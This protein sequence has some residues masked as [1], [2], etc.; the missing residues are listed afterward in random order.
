MAK[1]QKKIKLYSGHGDP[2]EF[3]ALVNRKGLKQR[4][5]DFF[6]FG[7]AL[8]FE[9]CYAVGFVIIQACYLAGLL[10]VLAFPGVRKTEAAK[11]KDRVKITRISLRNMAARLRLPYVRFGLVIFL[12]FLSGSVALFKSASFLAYGFEIK[13]KVLGVASEGVGHLTE[14]QKQL[15]AQD[16]NGAQDQLNQALHSFQQSQKDIQDTGLIFN[17]LLNVL[18][19]K[20]DA[21]KIL[22]GAQ[23]AS[24][25]ALSLTNFYA[26][27]G[28]LKFT[29]DGINAPSVSESFDK[30][31][32]FLETGRNKL[33]EASNLISQVDENNVP[34]KQRLSFVQ[35]K[36][37]L[38]NVSV[39]LNSFSSVFSV[40][41]N[42]VG[43]DKK[44]LVL[45]ENN[46]ELRPTGGFMGTFGSFN[47]SNGLIKS[48]KISS[49]YDLD[50]QLT[51]RIA[52]PFPLKQ[53]STVWHLRDSNWFS[54]FPESA[55]KI[56]QFYEKEGGETPDMTIVLT[57]NIVSDL[58]KITGPI[59][60][61]AY[62]AV[63]DS[64]NFV[65]STQVITSVNYDKNLNKPKQMLADFFP[66]LLQHLA[67]LKREQIVDVLTVF[68]KNLLS[69][70]VVLFSHDANLQSQLSSFNWTGELKNTD[71][72]FLQLTYA[73]LNGNK[74]DL[75][76]KTDVK[77]ET[78][79]AQDQINNTLTIRRTSTLPE[80][81]QFDSIGF[82]RI[83]VPEGSTLIST[84]GFATTP[85]AP[86]ED[87]TLKTDPDVL[88]WE[89]NSVK[90]LVSGTIIGKESGKTI[91][92]NWAQV[93][94]G[95]TQVITIKYKLPFTLK[96]IDHYSLLLQKQ[97]GSVNQTFEYSINFSGK[98]LEWKNF[99][100]DNLEANNL[101]G[102][103][104]LNRDYFLGMVFSQR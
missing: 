13:N 32:G 75:A 88:A 78:E 35:A 3:R 52:A 101:N 37:Q 71:R 30:M 59:K 1:L 94:G 89:S 28:Q 91:F 22:V 104:D 103:F 48:S 95:R 74:T 41:K 92:G 51:E 12:I 23:K 33:L 8:I 29:P 34:E 44:I 85:D 72:D 76:I 45:F 67:T 57:P 7:P 38:Q 54:N 53:V 93:W 99:S 20:R 68:Q 87:A 31:S 83:Y 84:S 39:A 96:N 60:M 2:L 56:T 55:K 86:K 46:N 47:V 73:N 90:D 18:P 64:D 49:I 65:E 11:I 62:N 36:Q 70:Q 81:K 69:K 26:E 43:G 97:A 27:M 6:K 79:I 19:Q 50:G 63:L 98:A 102:K 9:I 4:L 21:E 66:V 14:A 58:L 25:A 100:P 40:F 82:L 15:E 80:G 61:P 24:E 5:L 77:L 42:I 17:Q 10:L 16:I